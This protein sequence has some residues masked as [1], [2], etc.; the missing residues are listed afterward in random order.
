MECNDIRS[1]RVMTELLINWIAFDCL[2]ELGFKP[3]LFTGDESLLGPSKSDD[4]G[5]I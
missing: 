4:S 5:R 1:I 3:S 2:A